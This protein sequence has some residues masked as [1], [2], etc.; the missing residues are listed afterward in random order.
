MVYSQPARS[1]HD[2]EEALQLCEARRWGGFEDWRVPSIWELYTLL[3]T[4][5]ADQKYDVAAFP[6]PPPTELISSTSYGVSNTIWVM[7][8]T[9]GTAGPA[10]K[11]TPF[12][13]RC[14]RNM[15]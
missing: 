8:Q 12:A 13:L 11:L 9:S 3:D 6:E 5:A 15:P 4:A 7:N 14:V 2:W 1:T 10:D